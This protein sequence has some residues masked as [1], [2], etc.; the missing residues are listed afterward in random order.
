MEREEYRRKFHSLAYGMFIHYGLYT[1]HARGEW[2]MSKER[3]SNEEYFKV[4]PQFRNNGELAEAWCKTAACCGMR[5]ACLTTRHHD[6]YFIGKELVGAFCS[7]CRKY[8][9]GVGLY[10]SVG[11]WSDPDFRAGSSGANWKRFV[12][13]V[14]RQLRELMTDYGKIDYLFYDGCPSP[15]TWDAENLHKELRKLQSGLLISSRCGL[16]EDVASSE[17]HSNSHQGTWES[18]Y[19]M[20]DS[21]GYNQYDKKWKSPE[22]IITLL[23]TLRHNNGNLLLNVGP[24]P[25]GTIQPEEVRRL[26]IIGEWLKKNGEAVYNVSPHPFNYKDQEIS[27]GYGNIV[28]IMLQAD[29]LGPKRLICGIGNRIRKITLLADDSSIAFRQEADK[30]YLIGLPFKET[31]ELPRILKIELDGLPV[32]IHNP[33][34]PENDFRIC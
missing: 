24:G 21:W 19:T 32:G 18:C 16:D 22:E 14:H 7:A 9:L 3:M 20:N 23:M 15:R 12:E 13:K 8:G 6:G 11:D 1:I 34:W 4:I 25:D 28:Y 30:V 2:V 31:D 33:M 5:Y 26:K 17:G 29:Y 10:Y 27:T